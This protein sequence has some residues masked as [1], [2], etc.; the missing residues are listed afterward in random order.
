LVG[1]TW[2]QPDL[3]GLWW[4]ER[5]R[6]PFFMVPVRK[7]LSISVLLWLKNRSGWPKRPCR[8]LKIG[9]V[10]LDTY[11]LSLA[12]LR[13]NWVRFVIS[14]PMLEALPQSGLTTHPPARKLRWPVRLGPPHQIGARRYAGLNGSIQDIQTHALRRGPFPVKTGFAGYV[15]EQTAKL[16]VRPELRKPE[17]VPVTASSRHSLATADPP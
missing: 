10:F 12:F 11:A 8:R 2:I 5:T 15:K 9:F 14:P 16:C 17:S 3:V 6:E 7:D 1:F 13:K 4:G